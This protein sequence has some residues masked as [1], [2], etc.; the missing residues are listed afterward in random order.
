[1]G[2]FL[3]EICADARIVSIAAR[4]HGVVHR[5]QLLAAGVSRRQ[6][7]RRLA[8][9]RLKALH[10]GVYLVGAV[11]SEF[12]YPQAALFACG[13]DAALGCRSALSVWRLLTIPPL[14]GLG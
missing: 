4:Q 9:G 6:I 7:G 13:R 5:A 14:P 10:H 2:A 8:D 3:S 11:P 12:A 1:M